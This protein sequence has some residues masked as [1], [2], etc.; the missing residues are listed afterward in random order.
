[1]PHIRL[2]ERI[3]LRKFDK[4]YAYNANT[5]E[6]YELDKEAFDFLLGCDGRVVEVEE[7][8]LNFL[9][10]EGLVEISDEK[11]E[12]SFI[13]Q[14]EP[15]LRYLLLNI[16]WKCN[17]NC[18][19]CYV[20]QKES[21]MDKS[22]FMRTL[23]EFSEMGGL[24]L[25]ISGGEPLLHP[26]IWDFLKIA[27]DFPQ[28]VILLT[29]GYLINEKNSKEISKH[30]D[31][32]QIS[33]DGLEGHIMLRKRD[34]REVLKA[35]KILADSVD[36]SVSTMITNYNYSEFEKMKQLLE[37]AG[38]KKWIIDVP[39]VEKDIIP[40]IKKIAEIMMKYGFGELG[41]F[42][43]AD[44]ACG[45]HFCSV[46]PEGDVTKCGFFEEA[47]GNVREG[48]RV[49]WERLKKKFIWRLDELKCRCEYI[50]NCKGGCRYRALV[51]SGDLL[52]HDPV[53][54]SLYENLEFKKET[55]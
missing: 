31:E 22:I 24:K 35:I 42:S 53:M 40:S 28:R 3:L 50:K 11:V 45:A 49:C 10:S 39:T 23:E 18:E 12:N 27:R 55:F 19:H 38:I 47:V 4:Y 5:D 30:V 48:L 9:L 44:F 25:M 33:F 2:A 37:D 17:L 34:W 51:Y 21:F 1:M 7:E 43:E 41:H 54:C 52:S 36:I 16:T 20:N 26:E 13:E 46:T 6:L 15:S 32:V 14:R 8:L 29:N